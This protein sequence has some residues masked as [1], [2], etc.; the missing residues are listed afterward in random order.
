[1]D[2]C[3]VLHPTLGLA[4]QEQAAQ[5]GMPSQEENSLPHL[6]KVW[7]WR[8]T[9]VPGAGMGSREGDKGQ[10]KCILGSWWYSALHPVL[11]TQSASRLQVT[12]FTESPLTP[13]VGTKQNKKAVHKYTKFQGRWHVYVLSTHTRTHTHRGSLR[14]V[15]WGFGEH[16]LI[17]G[18]FHLIQFQEDLPLILWE[19]SRSC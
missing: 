10:V 12:Q 16:Y 3:S 5:A 8:L 11:L 18:P 9:V 14:S 6:C 17:R 1:M 4:W 13:Q 15:E 19:V 7:Y 2:S